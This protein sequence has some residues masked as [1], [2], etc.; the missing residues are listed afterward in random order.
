[1]LAG[2]RQD[3]GRSES[4]LL[5]AK[6]YASCLALGLCQE[7]GH[8]LTELHVDR[9]IYLDVLLQ[10][11]FTGSD[12]TEPAL[13]LQSAEGIV[14]GDPGGDAHSTGLRA[15]APF[16]GLDQAVGTHHGWV[17]TICILQSVSCRAQINRMRGWTSG[18]QCKQGTP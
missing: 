13:L 6:Y 5:S 1:M 2:F 3:L 10:V 4:C 14:I 7:M 18:H 15:S 17:R 16:G 9:N 8:P 11:Y 12:H